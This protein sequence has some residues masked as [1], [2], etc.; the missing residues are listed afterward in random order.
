[1]TISPGTEEY[2]AAKHCEC[3]AATLA[4]GPFKPLNT[5]GEPSSPPDIYLPVS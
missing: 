2:Q 4:A 5:I 1:M 3:W